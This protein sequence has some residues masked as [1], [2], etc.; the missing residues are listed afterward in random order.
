MAILSVK[1]A[2][3]MHVHSSPAPFVRIGDSAEIARWC[4]EAGMAGLVIKSHFEST[5]S[6]AHHA[7][8][9]VRDDF[10]DF[11][12]FSGIALNRGVG[13]V[14][15]GAVDLALGLGAKVVWLPTLDSA[16]HAKAYGSAGT[17]GIK[18]MTVETARRSR[19]T[20]YS[21][22]GPDRKLLPETKEVIDLVKDY[23]AV[24]ATGHSSK[25]EILAAFEY[26]KSIGLERF[27]VTHP[28]LAVPKLDMPTIIELAK[29]GAYMEF[30][31]INL[32]PVMHST[33]LRGM[34]EMIEAAT[35]ARSVLS[36]DGGQPFN[37]RPHESLRVGLQSLHEVGI[38]E[39]A[40][41]TM[42]MTNPMKL[43]GVTA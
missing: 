36:S 37:P 42:T 31:T 28:E 5:V 41:Q 8:T 39:S 38:S 25:E 43:L 14:N 4:A 26:A 20:L 30:C 6:K 3:D 2:Y 34:A 7:R 1:G 12:V 16:A 21:I 10:P 9:A 27:V 32:L 40:I 15:P 29:A 24:L 35:P 23:G 22:C 17:Y 13:G 33:S 19:E 18:A 11:K